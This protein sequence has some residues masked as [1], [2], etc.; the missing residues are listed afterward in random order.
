LNRRDH[1]IKLSFINQFESILDQEISYPDGFETAC[2]PTYQEWNNGTGG[3]PGDGALKEL[4]VL[5]RNHFFPS[6]ELEMPENWYVSQPI[7]NVYENYQGNYGKI[8]Y[9]LYLNPYGKKVIDILKIFSLAGNCVI[10][11][12]YNKIKIVENNPVLDNSYV[13]CDKLFEV[14]YSNQEV[15]R[16][17]ID[18][19]IFENDSNYGSAYYAVFG[20][21]IQ[22]QIMTYAPIDLKDYLIE[23]YQNQSNYAEYGQFGFDGRAKIECGDNF[24]VMNNR[25]LAKTI[26]KS[27]KFIDYS[28]EI[29]VQIEAVKVQ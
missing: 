29:P 21:A 14:S 1:T 18:E 26:K 17:E 16:K 2:Y 25:F 27:G 15:E 28:F 9:K 11:I 24:K 22:T 6:Y 5:F 23:F 7:R 13:Y 19:S 3:E 10:K 8:G 20:I 12:G 4:L